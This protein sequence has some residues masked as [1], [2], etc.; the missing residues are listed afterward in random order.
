MK[1]TT[2]PRSTVLI[3]GAFAC[4][5]GYFF[6][7]QVRHAIDSHAIVTVGTPP[8]MP[9][10]LDNLRQLYPL[11]A[12][13]QRPADAAEGAAPDAV[14]APQSLDQLFGKGT[15]PKGDSKAKAPEVVD[16]FAALNQT[17]AKN[18]RLD[19]LAPGVGAVINGAFIAIGDP[20][21]S[22][23][24][25]SDTDQKRMVVPRL[26]TVAPAGIT[27]R[28]PNGSRSIVVTIAQ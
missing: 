5:A 28:E 12:T 1:L 10:Q 20:I 4:I 13:P 17:K 11:L 3:I 22:L 24:Y 7:Q 6:D 2:S 14:L 26:S 21:P 16:Y 8:V 18:V 27:I 23:E 25:P 19:G 9:P 15:K